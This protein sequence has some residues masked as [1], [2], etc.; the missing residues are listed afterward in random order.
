MKN[1]S[2]R[3]LGVSALILVL[4]LGISGCADQMDDPATP[5]GRPVLNNQVSAAIAAFKQSNPDE[6]QL[7]TTSYGYAV[8]PSVVNFG[9]IVGGAG[10]YGEVFGG[11]HL[12]GTCSVSQGSIGA[13]VGG[14]EI[15]EYIFFRSRYA[16][17]DFEHNLAAFDAR[18]S[19]V[20][21]VAG[22]ASAVDYGPEVIVYVKPKV[23]LMVQAAIGGQQFQ[24]Y[25]LP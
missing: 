12:I 14:Q 20:A 21:T 3:Y 25:P 23:G 4:G 9:L 10:G 15:A 18:A 16:V 13:Q 2:R 24:F 8:L 11:G 17:E 5:A 19:A 1:K 22:A 6:A 7:F